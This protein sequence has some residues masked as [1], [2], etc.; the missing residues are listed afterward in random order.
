MNSVLAFSK[1]DLDVDVSM[2]IPLGVRV[3]ENRGEWV[4]KLNKSLYGIKK[5]SVI[6]F[7]IIKMFYKGGVTINIKLKLVYFTENTQLF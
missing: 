1:S 2:E 5:A 3:D 4:L 7:D 6:W